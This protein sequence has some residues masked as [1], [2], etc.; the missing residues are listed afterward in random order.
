MSGVLQ[1]SWDSACASER[2]TNG[3]SHAR[4]ICAWKTFASSSFSSTIG[5]RPFTR[6]TDTDRAPARRPVVSQTRRVRAV[7]SRK[8][9]PDPGTATAGP[10]FRLEGIVSGTRSS[11]AFRLQVP[12]LVDPAPASGTKR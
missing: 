4:T 1:S 2:G 5:G 9:P 11:R 8:S 6:N 3:F 7:T 12:F 10:F